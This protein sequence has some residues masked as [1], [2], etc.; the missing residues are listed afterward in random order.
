L[1]TV[2][3]SFCKKKRKRPGRDC[4]GVRCSG[5]EMRLGEWMV[6]GAAKPRS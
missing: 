5:V 1:D 3:G 2:A 4:S 6:E